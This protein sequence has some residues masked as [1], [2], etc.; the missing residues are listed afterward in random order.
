MNAFLV[1]PTVSFYHL[2]AFLINKYWLFFK[3]IFELYRKLSILDNLPDKLSL[4]CELKVI[5]INKQ[6]FSDDL[7]EF[8]ENF[9]AQG[10]GILLL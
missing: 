7:L 8:G 1:E 4:F 9:I 6:N 5:I 10:L 2:T 3:E